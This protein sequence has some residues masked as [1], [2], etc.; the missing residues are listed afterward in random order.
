MACGHRQV[1][2]CLAHTVSQLG[3]YRVIR[4]IGGAASEAY[5]ARRSDG[6]AEREFVLLPLEVNPHDALDVEDELARCKALKHPAVASV[7]ELVEYEDR[8][9]L[10]YDNVLGTNLRRLW[11]HLK[12]AGQRLSDAASIHV[13]YVLFDALAA[14]HEAV[15]L[16]GER[17][18]VVHGQL[19]PH[20]VLISWGGAVSVM[21]FG[22]SRVFALGLGK[23]PGPDDMLPYVAPESR[24]GAAPTEAA[25]VYSAAATVW[26]LL[27]G[28]LPNIED[29]RLT[30]VAE[31]GRQLPSELVTALDAALEPVAAH[32][33][34]TSRELAIAFARATGS[35]GRRDL[36]WTM[37]A[38]RGLPDLD[39]GSM[40]PETLLPNWHPNDAGLPTFGKSPLG[41]EVLQPPSSRGRRRRDS[42]PPD[43]AGIYGKVKSRQPEQRPTNPP[44]DSAQHGPKT[45]DSNWPPALGQTR[46]DNADEIAP[47]R[48]TWPG[49]IP[50]EAVQA[51]WATDA[52]PFAE[53]TVTPARSRR[54]A[55]MPGKRVGPKPPTTV[56]SSR[57]K[58]VKT[59]PAH[60][61]RRGP[62]TA[63]P[64]PAT[65]PKGRAARPG[66]APAQSPSD[67]SAL[68]RDAQPPTES[69]AGA[70][71]ASS[72]A[73]TGAETEAT[74]SDAAAQPTEP[75]G[76]EA[77]MAEAESRAE[78]PSAPEAP[79]PDA[80]P[81]PGEPRDTEA[82]T[83]EEASIAAAATDE[84]DEAE[85]AAGEELP[86]AQPP[87]LAAE[88]PPFEDGRKLTKA[89]AHPRQNV[90]AP[91][92]PPAAP[93]PPRS[94]RR[95]GLP[96]GWA[97]TAGV[98]AV[99]SFVAGLVISVGPVSIRFG[100]ESAEP[101]RRPP[102]RSTLG[103]GQPA[104]AARSAAHP[105]SSA[106]APVSS[107]PNATTSAPATQPVATDADV[108]ALPHDKGL[109]VV[110]NSAK[111]LHVYVNGRRMG[112][113]NQKLEAQC[114][115]VHVR[116]GD[117][118]LA[119]WYSEGR[120]VDVECQ[121]VTTVTIA[122]GEPIPVGLSHGPAPKGTAREPWTPYDAPAK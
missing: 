25:N 118:P 11:H 30:A 105:S 12:Q 35:N 79:G 3:A 90:L 78:A 102:P 65:D 74:A 69:E 44:A 55:T 15:D 8:K 40:P 120:A 95:G 43:G 92:S 50:V 93:A 48:E 121:S 103:R 66:S 68:A 108:S 37:T 116:L 53:V 20:R 113:T 16:D 86:R 98:L 60:P 47:E 89:P 85:R 114:G 56:R 18:P 70:A 14:A 36:G 76:T 27:S 71:A 54:G 94:R 21:G 45:K 24:A 1:A 119:S 22:W 2:T 26:S 62:T 41:R 49:P 10:V 73:A 19:G 88:Q 42:L 112:P 51:A 23:R 6:G 39:V 99:L 110:Q 7:V 9:V 67:E 117:R 96:L 84:A 109:L 38:S 75:T 59:D 81:T 31:L 122:T 97:I 107:S 64:K 83:A 5:L 33:T 34:I 77:N 82:D 63:R 61:V 101:E 28:Q 32:R 115:M 87:A 17:A 104:P 58:R 57:A 72:Q 29:K 100:G 52:P 106:P 4:S 13:G 80:E 46:W 91:A 111:G